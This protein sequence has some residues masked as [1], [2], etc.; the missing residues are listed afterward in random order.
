MLEILGLIAAIWLII[1]VQRLRAL[2]AWPLPRRRYQLLAAM[3]AEHA[4]AVFDELQA[5]VATLGFLGPF[6]LRAERVD[7]E[8][9]STPLY[10]LYR[11]PDGCG[12]L[13]VSAPANV[14]HPHQA[15]TFFSHRL[16]D[17]R[18]AISQPFD[19]GFALLQG[20]NLIVRS[21]SEASLSE[22]WQ[23]HLAW[24]SGLGSEPQLLADEDFSGVAGELFERT[25]ERM[26]ASAS[27]REVTPDLALLRLPMAIKAMQ[28]MRK[29]AKPPADPR[30]VPLAR[31]ARLT[32]VQDST[33]QRS[34]PRD[35]QWGLFV[36]SV[37]LFMAV[38]AL[39]WDVTLAL[40]ILLVVVL[41]EL[42]H[43]L[44]MRAF[45]YRNVHMLA[46]PLVGGV[47]IGHDVNPGASKRAW[48]SLMGP[49]PGIVIGWLLLAIV[50]QAGFDL[51]PWLL[52]LA[53][54]FLFVNYLN[55][56]PI[57]PLD[58]AHVV[59]A[60]L[61]VRWAKVQTVLIAIAAVVGA[62]FAWQ[63]SFY[64]LTVVALLQLPAL[65]ANWRLHEV[66]LALL[67]TQP[68]TPAEPRERMLQILSALEAK[69]GPTP[70]ALVRVRQALSVRQ[71]I[72][73][74]PMGAAARMA[75]SLVY[76][77]LL[78][79]PVV[80]LL[81]YSH[82]LGGDA[83]LQARFEAQASTRVALQAEAA[84]LSLAT[85]VRDLAIG[86]DDEIPEAASSMAFARAEARLGRPLPLELRSFYEVADG[87]PALDLLPLDQVAPPTS[88]Q[89]EMLSG[90]DHRL[91]LEDSV[92]TWVELE[93]ATAERW[94]HLGGWE[95][96]PLFYLPD[97]HPRL[98][99]TRII[100]YLIESPGVHTSLRDYL[101]QQWAEQKMMKQLD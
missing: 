33:S 39:F 63:Y 71:R 85:L 56:L 84:T 49:L 92:G 31:L 11:A 47:A 20:G 13:W 72:E 61:P 101:D 70:H 41:H 21:A 35:V 69:L 60:L 2:L 89:V 80:G 46:L 15:M 77:S 36:V 82:L 98:P 9:E 19:F 10:A 32:R 55:V 51:P 34:P 52:S 3:P 95:D 65:A 99:T 23:A 100:N 66:E 45:G 1:S 16:V 54:V 53:M 74:Q 68:S 94:W 76:L 75:T 43:F 28:A 93:A 73:V 90:V 26:I 4:D 91:H 6:W 29:L 27:L 40:S 64:L 8:P 50:W 59:E 38:G 58:G 57:P 96:A 25:R 44:A 30:P 7:G 17:G 86:A 48:M 79:V 14:A 5:E 97:P 88:A 24:L 22:Q 83:E 12:L 42:G 78:L 81:G 62:Y 37:V 18:N 87:L 67:Q